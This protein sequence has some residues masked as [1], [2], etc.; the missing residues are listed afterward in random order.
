MKKILLFIISLV[1]F[2]TAFSQ[3]ADELNMQ[4]KDLIQQG[5]YND[6]FPILKKS[7]ELGNA[8]AQYN[9]GYFLQ[10]GTTGIKNEKEAIDWY[11]KS[12]NNGFNNAH[13]AMMMAYGNGNG[14]EQNSEKAFE[15]ALKCANNDDET[16]MWNV[17]NCYLSGNGVKPDNSKFKEWIIRL[18]KLPNPENLELSGNITSARLE[19]ANFFKNG[20]YFEKDNYQSY[21]WYLIYNESKVD[22]SILKQEE[23]IKEIKELEKDLSKQQIDNAPK[24]AEKLLGRNLNNLKEL[25]KNSL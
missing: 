17:I 21:L 22:F 5:K 6:A 8:E 18:A 23:A 15:Y 10:S 4:A 9:L 13:Y 16:C 11:K 14:I 12:S 19:L 3:N 20:K 24:D 7:A 25:Y 1:T 2:Q